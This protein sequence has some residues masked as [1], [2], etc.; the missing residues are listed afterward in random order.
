MS[1]SQSHLAA[2]SFELVGGA[3]VRPANDNGSAVHEGEAPSAPRPR[4]LLLQFAVVA[5]VRARRA[6]ERARRARARRT[7]PGVRPRGGER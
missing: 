7:P 1:I 4:Q 2:S 6:D 5:M 3:D